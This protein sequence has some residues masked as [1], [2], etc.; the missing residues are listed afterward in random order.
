[1]TSVTSDL[2][3]A[4]KRVRFEGIG[5]NFFHHLEHRPRNCLFV[6]RVAGEVTH[7][8]AISASHAKAIARHIH[9]LLQLF[10]L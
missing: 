1:M 4:P 10:R 8:V 3:I 5:V 6:Y 7:R 9:G 2:G